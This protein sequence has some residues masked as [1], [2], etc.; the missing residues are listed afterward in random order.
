MQQQCFY[1][2]VCFP[3]FIDAIENLNVPE[4]KVQNFMRM[5]MQVIQHYKNLKQQRSSGISSTQDKSAALPPAFL[6]AVH[7]FFSSFIVIKGLDIFK[8]LFEGIQQGI[9]EMFF[10]GYS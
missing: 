9:T 7:L 1:E 2:A 3:M 6:R 5:I 4:E 8:K 10:N